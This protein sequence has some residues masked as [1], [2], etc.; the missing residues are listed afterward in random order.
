MTDELPP[1]A[2]EVANRLIETYVS[3]ERNI[4]D[5]DSFRVAIVKAVHEA[6]EEGL[7]SGLAT[8]SP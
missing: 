3:P 7:A 2:I 5:F 4:L 1:W 8:G 6:Y